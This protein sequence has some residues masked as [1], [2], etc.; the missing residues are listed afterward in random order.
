MF[1]IGLP[2]II[3]GAVGIGVVLWLVG[4]LTG[5]NGGQQMVLCPQCGMNV[6][7]I[8]WLEHC[9][10]EVKETIIEGRRVFYWEC[11][12]EMKAWDN[13]AGAG[14]GLVLHR[15]EAHGASPIKEE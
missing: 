5:R 11:C 8:R 9:E 12:N 13:R 2:E 15:I 14:A 10:S 1:G 4:K 7:G 3:A 6:E